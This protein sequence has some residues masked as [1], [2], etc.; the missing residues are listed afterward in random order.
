MFSKLTATGGYAATAGG[1]GVGFYALSE[2]LI[3]NSNTT[4]VTKEEYHNNKFLRSKILKR[5]N[6]M[7]NVLGVDMS[8]AKRI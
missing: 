3:N 4:Q 1:F 5:H 2:S 8:Y 6:S 7:K